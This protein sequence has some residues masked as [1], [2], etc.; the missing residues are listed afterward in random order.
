MLDFS[1]FD[2]YIIFVGGI[3]WPFSLLLGLVSLVLAIWK[4]KRWLPRMAL[5]ALAL[6]TL[7]PVGTVATFVIPQWVREYR[8]DRS[9]QRHAW[10]LDASRRVDGFTIPA[11][12]TLQLDEA[13]DMARKERATLADID[14]ISL[15]A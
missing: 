3:L 6:V 15:S 14:W 2:L 1:L 11:G 4:A 8:M 9:Q 7:F 12:S 13:F 5:L 10:K